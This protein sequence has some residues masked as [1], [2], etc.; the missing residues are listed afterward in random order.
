MSPTSGTRRSLATIG[1]AGALV[2]AGVV[3]TPPARAAGQITVALRDGV[4]YVAGND[5]ANVVRLYRASDGRILVTAD[6]HIERRGRTPRIGNVKSIRISVRGGNDIVRLHEG[7]P[8]ATVFGDAGDDKLVGGTAAETLRGGPGG[9][10]LLG[11]GGADL[12]MGEAG[13]DQLDAQAGDDRLVGGDGADTLIGAAGDDILRGELGDDS[14]LFDQEVHPGSDVVREF[15]GQGTDEVW[16]WGQTDVTFSLASAAPQAVSSWLTVKLEAVD[17]FENLHGGL[18]HDTLAGNALAN[19]F[20]GD[21]GNDQISGAGGADTYVPGENR[22]EWMDEQWWPGYS[23]SDTISD[24]AE[25]DTV[26]LDG[27]K[28]VTAGIGTSTVQISGPYES[29]SVT[30]TG[31]T[32]DEE[33]FS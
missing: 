21:D 22:A 31:H 30:A 18:G 9:D 16:F 5:T 27:G 19:H 28:E 17:T 8:R 6:S 24:F 23:G 32:F 2:A 29:G 14:Y 20:N 1:A 10:T 12:L 25:D 13:N 7:L 4:L 26:D 33:D 3:A 11:G 15:A